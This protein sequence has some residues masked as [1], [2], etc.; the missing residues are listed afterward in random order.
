MSMR[1]DE[2]HES[3]DVIDRRGERAPVGGMGGSGGLGWLSLLPLLVRSRFG[4]VI[5]AILLLVSLFGGLGGLFGV[6]GDEQNARGPASGEIKTPD[7]KAQFVGF[8]LDDTQQTWRSLLGSQYRNAKLVLFTG[9]TQTACGAGRAVTGP[10]YCP[11]DER[12]YIDLSFYDELEQRL[13]AGGDFA[14]AYVIAHEIGH[15]VQN[16]LG[17]TDKVHGA[18]RSEQLGSEGMSVRL[19][20]QADCFAGIWAHST[21]NRGIL[22]SGDLEEA[23]GAAAAIGDDRLERQATGHV[24]PEKWTHGSS[25]QRVHWFKRGYESGAMESC[26]TFTP[27]VL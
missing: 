7:K 8:V 4:W 3:P 22:E 26:D 9:A 24:Q 15:H 25:E 1:W 17:I 18:R 23:L 10:F 5:I 2:G 12:V 19:E 20:L 11:L 14:Q 21:K 16:L 6:G 27:G 13:G